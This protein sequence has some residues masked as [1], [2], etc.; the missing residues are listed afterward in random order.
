MPLT[1]CF[2]LGQA[3]SKQVENVVRPFFV[4]YKYLVY[5]H[6]QR[7]W[8]FDAKKRIQFRIGLGSTNKHFICLLQLMALLHGTLGA[9]V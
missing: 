2:H 6:T 7:C 4:Y 9:T 3:T 8:V 5:L 1:R